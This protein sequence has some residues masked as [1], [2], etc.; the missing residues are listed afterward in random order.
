MIKRMKRLTQVTVRVF[1]A[2]LLVMSALPTFGQIGSEPVE[3]A[4]ES[5]AWLAF[6]LA[7]FFGIAVA[8]GCLMSPKRTHQ[9]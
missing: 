6:V 8:V 1:I 9:D 7:I 5:G 2:S 3:P 4:P